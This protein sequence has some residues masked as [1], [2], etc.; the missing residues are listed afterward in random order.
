MFSPDSLKAM[1]GRGNETE[2]ESERNRGPFRHKY[3]RTAETLL[4]KLFRRCQIRSDLKLMLKIAP[5]CTVN[6]ENQTV[7]QE[8]VP[9][10]FAIGRF[11]GM[12]TTLRCLPL[13]G[14]EFC[15]SGIFVYHMQPSK[16]ESRY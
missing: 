16:F 12:Q 3:S 6:A 10:N 9:K 2:K 14:N 5:R 15:L 13:Y 8:Y 11:Q 7:L 1:G 4:D